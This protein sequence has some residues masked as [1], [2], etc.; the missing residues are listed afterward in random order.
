MTINVYIVSPMG[1][2]LSYKYFK[3]ISSSNPRTYPVGC[4]LLLKLF[5]DKDTKAERV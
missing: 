1:Q 2:G 3:Y 4:V 5:K